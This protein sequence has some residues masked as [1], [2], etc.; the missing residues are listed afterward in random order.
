VEAVGID[1]EHGYPCAARAQQFDG[2]CADPTGATCD[3]GNSA[4]EVIRVH[5]QS[6]IAGREG[7]RDWD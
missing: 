2:R 6:Y 7:A 4:A 5:T 3:E 1:V